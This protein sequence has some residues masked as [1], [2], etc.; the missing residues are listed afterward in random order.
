MRV[1]VVTIAAALIAASPAFAAPMRPAPG[2][3]AYVN[4]P[5]KGSRDL[6]EIAILLRDFPDLG[7]RLYE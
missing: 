5:T 1:S 6:S 4:R 3:G 2:S 7:A